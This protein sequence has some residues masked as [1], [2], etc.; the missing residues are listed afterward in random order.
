M[1]KTI[2]AIIYC[3]SSIYILGQENLIDDLYNQNIYICG[4]AVDAIIYADFIDAYPDLV[5]LY[6]IKPPIIQSKFI[7]AFYRLNETEEVLRDRLL[8]YIARSD[9]FS[10][11]EFPL[12]P[13][14]EKVHA[15]YL[16]ML[17]NDY[18]TY[19]YVLELINNVGLPNINSYTFNALPLILS[20]VPEAEAEAKTDLLYFWEN[21]LNPN[22]NRGYLAMESLVQKYGL[23]M[24]DE[25]VNTFI[26]DIDHSKKIRALQLL[27]ELN[28][29]D[30]NNLLTNRLDN[31]QFWTIRLNIADTLLTKF[32]EPS[33]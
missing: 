16:L 15:T 22:S 12:D 7:D 29:A 31:E 9:E 6:E 11:E 21:D 33:I 26:N 10:N 14:A 20:N 5:D 3:L 13:L 8:D 2:I 30:L 27:S 32:G 25:L 23:E 4:P 1:K 17:I 24:S 28:F 18:S 19:D